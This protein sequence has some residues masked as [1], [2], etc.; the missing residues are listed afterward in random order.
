MEDIIGRPLHMPILPIW[1][2]RFGI[3]F[4]QIWSYLIGMDPLYTNKSLFI[5]QHGN[6]HIS[7]EKARCELGYSPRPLADSLRDSYEWF[8]AQGKI[9]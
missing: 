7:N 4:L 9:N 6:Q 5:I 3:P 2:A 1:L 8:K